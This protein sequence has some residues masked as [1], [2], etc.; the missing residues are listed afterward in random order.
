MKQADASAMSRRQSGSS[1]RTSV[2]RKV[3]P[4]RPK[5]QRADFRR[6]AQIRDISYSRTSNIQRST[7]NVQGKKITLPCATN[8][9]LAISF[10]RSLVLPRWAFDVRCWTFF[11]TEFSRVTVESFEF[12]LPERRWIGIHSAY[13]LQDKEADNMGDHPQDPPSSRILYS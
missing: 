6:S 4:K 13:Q 3:P 2:M 7:S 9:N 11:P 10:P 5:P 12:S 1:G 8:M